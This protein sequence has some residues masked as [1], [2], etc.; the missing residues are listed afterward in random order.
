[1]ERVQIFLFSC[2]PGLQSAAGFWGLDLAV[3]FSGAPK[4]DITK[5][6]NNIHLASTHLCLALFLAPSARVDMSL[7]LMHCR[8]RGVVEFDCVFS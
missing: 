3:L 5:P 2:V 7:L 4:F 6:T 1:M 8:E